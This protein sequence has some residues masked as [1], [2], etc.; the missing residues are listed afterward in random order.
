MDIQPTQQQT[1]DHPLPLTTN[2]LQTYLERIGVEGPVTVDRKGLTR[3]HRAHLLNVTWEAID[4][5]MG[6]PTSLDPAAAHAKIVHGGRGGWCFEMN[7]LFGAALQA[8]GFKVMRLAGCVD[9]PKLGNAAIGNHLTLR[10]DLD[11]P[12]LAEVGVADALIDPV[13]MALG[14]FEQRGFAFRI[15]PAESGWLRLQNHK[16][17]VAETVDLKPDHC[18][19][20]ALQRSM[21]WLQRDAASPF[22]NALAVF[23]HVEDGYYSLQNDVLRRVRASGA[24]DSF[25]RD[26]EHLAEVFET[27]FALR[28]PQVRYIWDKLVSMRPRTAA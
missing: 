22:R 16:L 5:F 15:E 6:W 12:F 17:G 11:R 25:V 28:V 4:C 3:L 13:P 9:L 7:G 20:A 26:A 21:E 24:E 27:V 18:D 10:V 23:R 14:A 8:L 1:S 19:E 2:Q